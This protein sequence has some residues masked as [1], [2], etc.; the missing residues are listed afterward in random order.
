[1]TYLKPRLNIKKIIK[2][3]SGCQGKVPYATN[4]LILPEI[5]LKPSKSKNSSLSKKKKC[6]TKFYL[7][8]DLRL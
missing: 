7:I 4:A 3:L 6:I 1:M 5:F 8:L 2:R